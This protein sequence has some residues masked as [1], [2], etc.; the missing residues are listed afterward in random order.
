[1]VITS[2]YLSSKTNYLP[3]A[4]NNFESAVVSSEWNVESHNRLASLDKVQPLWVD[5][6]LGGTGLVEKLDLLEEAGLAEGV[7]SFAGLGLGCS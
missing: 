1:M 6:G 2:R 7:K 5:S 4:R 3:V